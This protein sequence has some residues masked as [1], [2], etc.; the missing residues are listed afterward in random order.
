M[1]ISF[2]KLDDTKNKNLI[3]KF[4]KNSGASSVVNFLYF[5]FFHSLLSYKY[6]LNLSDFTI[7][8]IN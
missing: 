6:S 1:I 8:A 3:V 5:R 2:T 4:Y 7:L